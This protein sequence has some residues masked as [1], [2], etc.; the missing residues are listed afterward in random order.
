MRN[1]AGFDFVA[2]EA[3]D[4]VVVDRQAILREH[5]VAELL[6]LFQ[7]LVIHAG[8][9]VIRTAQQDDAETVF[10]FELFQHL[11]GGAAHRH[12]VEHVE[13]AE[14]L[15]DG[16]F[17][18]LGRQP[19]DVFELLK[20]L[21]LQ[22]VGLGQVDEGVQEEDAFLGEQIAFLDERRFDRFRRG[23]HGG[24]RAAGLRALQLAGQA[25]DHREEDDVERLLGVHLVEQVVHVR[26]AELGGEARVDGAALGALFVQLLEV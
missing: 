3:P 11:A 8:I 2:E 15:F 1:L 24:A 23:G 4:D 7:D 13:C 26:N 17:V 9:V 5:R 12:V 19:Q 21:P 10:A 14:P 6:E 18:L 20:H 25:V 16:P 22:E